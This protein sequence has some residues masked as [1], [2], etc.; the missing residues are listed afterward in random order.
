MCE[1]LSKYRVL[2]FWILICRNLSGDKYMEVRIDSKAGKIASRLYMLLSNDVI[3]KVPP[4]LFD[5]NSVIRI[6][7]EAYQ[8]SL[9]NLRNQDRIFTETTFGKDITSDLIN[10]LAYKTVGLDRILPFLFDNKIN[11][12]YLDDPKS[13]IYVDHSIFGR[14][15]TNINL[16]KQEIEKLIYIAKLEG[17]TIVSEEHPSLKTELRTDDFVIRLSFDFFPLTAS[18]F[19]MAIRKI[20]INTINPRI[21]IPDSDTLRKLT[22]IVFLLAIRAN[23]VIVG[24]P[25]SGK[26][27]LASLLLRYVPSY[28]RVIII[29]DV[30]EIITTNLS[31]KKIVRI[32]VNPIEANRRYEKEE[33]ITKLLH[34]SPDYF[35]IG[36]LQD[37][38]DNSA[39][40]HALSMG[41]KGIATVHASN[42]FELVNRW[43]RI[44]DIDSSRISLVDAL[45]FMKKKVTKNE[46]TRKIDKIYLL[47]S[48]LTSMNEETDNSL[49]LKKYRGI[50]VY[51]DLLILDL[52]EIIKHVPSIYSLRVPLYLLLNKRIYTISRNS[53]NRILSK[54]ESRFY[55]I[56]EILSNLQ[57]DYES[58]KKMSLVVEEINSIMPQI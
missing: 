15:V 18:Q 33:E 34:R 20:N 46:I 42:L 51:N 2:I 9:N 29:E 50:R 16:P 27:T 10:Y 6:L 54:L 32:R 35:V 1:K 25:G 40:F 57:T 53:V 39:F 37:R 14:L 31:D 4:Y 41:L 43:I 28:W 11:E 48:D 12:I 19:S 22:Y 52:D 8:K 21:F 3:S 38:N 24:E 13:N 45:V 36:E 17:R 7:K 55:Q 58:I 56:Y 5:F 30:R 49:Y 23:I 26:T 47:G 44:Y